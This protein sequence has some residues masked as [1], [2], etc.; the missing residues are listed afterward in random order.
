MV[1]EDDPDDADFEPDFGVTSGR[2]ANK[3]NAVVTYSQLIL[4]LVNLNWLTS[5][6]VLGLHKILDV[7]SYFIVRCSVTLFPVPTK[8]YHVLQMLERVNLIKMD[9][10]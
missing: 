9:D 7:G 4:E 1:A 3:V 5:L 6:N 10:H 8:Y 2:S